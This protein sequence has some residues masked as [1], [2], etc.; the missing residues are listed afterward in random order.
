MRWSRKQFGIEM[1]ELKLD[2]CMNDRQVK[3]VVWIWNSSV[4]DWQMHEWQ[5]VFAFKKYWRNYE[6]SYS[7]NLMGPIFMGSLHETILK[8]TKKQMRWSRKQF[9][10]EMAELKLDRCM[11]DRQVKAVVW[12]WNSSVTDWQMHEWQTVFAFKK[13]WR[14]YELSYS[15]N[16]LGSTPWNN[17]KKT[18][19]QMRW[20][21]KQFGIEM[22]ELKLDRC[23]NDR[24]VKAVVWIWKQFSYGLADAWVIDSVCI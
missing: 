8:K 17:L 13:Y 21:R 20:S 16:L 10:I 6:F 5:T 24:Q 1:A 9:G 11:N 4:T 22:A 23:M 19:K 12:I 2:R 3:A 14:N 15:Y 18:K 7:Y